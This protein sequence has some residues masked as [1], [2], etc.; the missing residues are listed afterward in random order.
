M[1][2]WVVSEPNQTQTNPNKNQ[3]KEKWIWK[4]DWDGLKNNNKR[5][6]SD[7]Q[8]LALEIILHGATQGLDLGQILLPSPRNHSNWKRKENLEHHLNLPKIQ[9][10]ELG[11]FGHKWESLSRCLYFSWKSLQLWMTSFTCPSPF[12]GSAKDN[13]KTQKLLTIKTNKWKD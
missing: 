12:I 13:E 3:T 7:K 5:E 4:I 9:D 6:Q 1:Y 10:I 8:D 2:M 11:I